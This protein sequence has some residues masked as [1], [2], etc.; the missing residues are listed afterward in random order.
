MKWE[1]RMEEILMGYKLAILHTLCNIHE[2][3]TLS[4]LCDVLLEKLFTNYFHLQQALAEL[5]ETGFVIREKQNNL[6]LFKVSAQ[7]RDAYVYLEKDL[8]ADIRHQILDRLHQLELDKPLSIRAVADYE[9]TITGGTQVHCIL[10]EG[11]TRIIDMHLSVPGQ[12]AAQAVAM[13]WPHKARQIYEKL[14]E[15]LL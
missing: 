2:S 6:T 9:T 13:Q 14:M 4:Q 11:M 15:E 7:G 3:A 12:E 5:E 8:S 10:L 1:S